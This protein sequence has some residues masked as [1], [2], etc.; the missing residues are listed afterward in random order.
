MNARR[1]A[2]RFRRNDAMAMSDT[3]KPAETRRALRPSARA[4]VPV[5]HRD[6]GALFLLRDALAPHPL[7]GE[8]RAAA[9]QRRQ[10]DR[11]CR[12]AQLLRIDLRTARHPAV[13]VAHLRALHCARVSDAA[14]RRH[15]GG[16]RA[17]PA[18]HRH[19]RRGADGGRPFHDGVPA[20]VP[21]RAPGADLRQRRVQAQHHGADRRSLSRPA[22]RAAT[23]PI[24]SSMSASISA[25]SWRRWFAARSARRSAG[26]TA[27]APP[28]SA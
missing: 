3:P 16:P 4:D 20:A 27:L 7:H 23:A 26:T 21:V 19:P 10:R 8:V 5:H 24:R 18:P 1:I 11:A 15:A 22:I 2:D 28:A 17:G 6:V 9:R 25:R 14:V 13:R 12:T